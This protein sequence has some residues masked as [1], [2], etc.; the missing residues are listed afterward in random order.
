MKEE[1]FLNFNA[2]ETKI[3][4]SMVNFF[5]KF[6]ILEERSAILDDI[7]EKLSDSVSSLDNE[8]LIDIQEKFK[9]NFLDQSYSKLIS[10]FEK[11]EEGITISI[12][13]T[14]RYANPAFI[15]LLGYD[16][17]ESVLSLG[18]IN[19]I[20]K[21]YYQKIKEYCEN[22][23]KGVIVPNIY[24]IELIRVNG[25][26]ILIDCVN[27]CMP[28]Q[29]SNLLVTFYI[30]LKNLKNLDIKLRKSEQVGRNIFNNS[31]FLI[32]QFNLKTNSFD[33]ISPSSIQ[34]FGYDPEELTSLEFKNLIDLIHPED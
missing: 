9:E 15:K 20:S 28:F 27:Y 7:T 11:A 6:N 16:S 3:M 34:E 31:S 18:F 22:R 33:Y 13:E 24:E 21:Q 10:S 12:D 17:L 8:D 19:L 26:K 4:F 29:D 14:I 23:L 2:E 5:K 1:L 30:S 32:Y 25:A